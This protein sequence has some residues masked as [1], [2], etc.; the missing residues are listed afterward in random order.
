MAGAQRPIELRQPSRS[1]CN[2]AAHVGNRPVFNERLGN[3]FGCHRSELHAHAVWTYFLDSP[4]PEISSI[5]LLILEKEK[6]SRAHHLRISQQEIE[7]R[8]PVLEAFAH[9]F[10]AD[11]R[12]CALKLS[13]SDIRRFGADFGYG[14]V[15]EPVAVAHFPRA[16]ARPRSVELVEVPQRLRQGLPCGIDEA[17]QIPLR[18]IV[19]PAIRRGRSVRG[20]FAHY[21]T[22]L[23]CNSAYFWPDIEIVS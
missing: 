18:D 21:E 13:K 5:L 23:D 19:I 14:V 10:L 17:A 15:I 9:E 20:S 6:G 7:V 3:R 16:S 12:K 2:F 1:S 11:F 22:L 4:H 8:F